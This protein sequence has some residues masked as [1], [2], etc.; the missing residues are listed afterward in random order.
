ML[1]HKIRYVAA[2]PIRPGVYRRNFF[3]HSLENL[4]S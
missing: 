2:F 1:K 4:E 3:P